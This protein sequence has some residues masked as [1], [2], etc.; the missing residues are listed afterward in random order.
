VPNRRGGF[1]GLLSEPPKP[2]PDE[3]PPTQ[4]RTIELVTVPAEE[5]EPTPAA[6]PVT[7]SQP[8]PEPVPQAKSPTTAAT[9]AASDSGQAG[10]RRAATSIRIQQQVADELE[11]AWLRAKSVDLR[12]SYSEYTSRLLRRALQEETPGA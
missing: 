6:E 11:A 3:E 8:A 5:V 9:P 10:K 4:K 7:T 2:L 12:L 1:T